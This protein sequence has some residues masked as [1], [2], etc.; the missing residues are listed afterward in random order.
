MH[1]S[2]TKNLP[3]LE[4]EL[5]KLAKK[6]ELEHDR[7]MKIHGKEIPSMIDEEWKLFKDEKAAKKLNRQFLTPSA[8]APT[9][10]DSA[11]S[12]VPL[13]RMLIT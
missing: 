1:N 8:A 12:S 9:R 7:K 3:K 6:F 5:I 11:S 2:I 4:A 10:I 13:V